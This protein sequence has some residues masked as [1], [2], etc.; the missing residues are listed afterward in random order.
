LKWKLL[1]L[2]FEQ[3]TADPCLFIHEHV[4]CI[5]YVNDCLF[6]APNSADIDA[7]INGLHIADMELNKDD[8]VASFL[9]VKMNRSESGSIELLQTGLIDCVIMAMGLEGAA[10]KKTPTTATPLLK[11][12]NGDDCTEALNFGSV[13][14]MFMYLCGHS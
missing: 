8:D 9:G 4:I 7:M 13:V 6:F 14:G 5:T 12:A 11:D 10:P 2:G 1:A 3:S